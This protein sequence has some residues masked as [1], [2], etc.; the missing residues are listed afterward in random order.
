MC[1]P[2]PPQEWRWNSS[3]VIRMNVW[4]RYRKMNCRNIHQLLLW[5][6]YPLVQPVREGCTS[7]KMHRG[8]KISRDIEGE[9]WHGRAEYSALRMNVESRCCN[10]YYILFS[11]QRKYRQCNQRRIQ[12][13]NNLQ[14]KLAT[15]TRQAGISE[16]TPT[17]GGFWG[18]VGSQQPANELRAHSLHL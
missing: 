16:Q 14:E 13:S 1:P 6:T 8:Q 7:N 9:I 5:I 15:G 2:D 10:L 3:A 11:L 4:M 18:T 17:K 12:P